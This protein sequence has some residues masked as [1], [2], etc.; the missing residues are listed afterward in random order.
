MFWYKKEPGEFKE[1]IEIQSLSEKGFY[2][3][4]MI[5]NKYSSKSS[6]Q[7]SSYFKNSSKEKSQYTDKSGSNNIHS[8]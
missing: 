2:R 1:T 6:D 4:L 5:K 3:G 7:I 8:A